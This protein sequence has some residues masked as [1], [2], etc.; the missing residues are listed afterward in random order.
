MKMQL[1]MT[2]NKN[3]RIYYLP[4]IFYLTCI[5]HW[6]K[7][8]LLFHKTLTHRK[9]LLIMREERLLKQIYS[10]GANLPQPSHMRSPISFSKERDYHKEGTMVFSYNSSLM[11]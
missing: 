1:K 7:L 10:K 9:M 6:V 11:N 3:F 2:L 4:I 8:R 5:L